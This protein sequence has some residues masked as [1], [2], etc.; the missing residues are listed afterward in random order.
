LPGGK[1]GSIDYFITD[2]RSDVRMILTE[3]TQW[4]YTT[5]S[6]EFDD[7][8]QELEEE[9]YGSLQNL[10]RVDKPAAWASNNSTYVSRLNKHTYK[11]GPSRLLKVMAGD[12]INSNVQYYYQAPVTNSVGS[13]IVNDVVAMLANIIGPS[14]ATSAVAKAA[15]PQI[16]NQAGINTA[17][18]SLLTSNASGSGGNMPKA[19][20]NIVFFDAESPESVAIRETFYICTG[21]KLT[22]TGT[23]SR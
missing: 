3:E 10:S 5:A 23:K 12:L 17:F 13:F 2:H 19:Y 20:L 22:G 7:G 8:R 21:G 1:K 15:A 14:A 11:V 16:A 6:M 18:A 9:L 4:S